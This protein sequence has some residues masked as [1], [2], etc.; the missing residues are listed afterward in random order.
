M[1]SVINLTSEKYKVIREHITDFG[2]KAVGDV[3]DLFPLQKYFELRP[4]G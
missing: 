1:G 2:G 3:K 4:C